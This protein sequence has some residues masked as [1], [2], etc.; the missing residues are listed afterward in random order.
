MKSIADKLL[1]WLQTPAQKEEWRKLKEARAIQKA[2]EEVV[3][4][5]M[6]NKNE[7]KIEPPNPETKL[8]NENFDN[9]KLRPLLDQAWDL[10]VKIWTRQAEI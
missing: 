8:Y 7:V 2:R 1:N 4:K 5:M 3:K 6:F 9:K 10:L